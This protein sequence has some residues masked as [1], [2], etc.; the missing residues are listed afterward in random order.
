MRCTTSVYEVWSRVQSSEKQCMAIKHRVA[1]G[2]ELREV[3]S[4]ERFVVARGF[5]GT[6]RSYEQARSGWQNLKED[7]T[8]NTARVSVS[9]LHLPKGN[10]GTKEEGSA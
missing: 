2:A 1:K 3:Y 4:C 6:A 10:C 9:S 7:S 8:R 5:E